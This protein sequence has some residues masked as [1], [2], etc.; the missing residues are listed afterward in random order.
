MWICR[1]RRA[2]MVVSSKHANENPLTDRF[3]QVRERLRP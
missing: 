1:N 3:E 2:R